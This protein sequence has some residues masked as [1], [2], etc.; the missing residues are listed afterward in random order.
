MGQHPLLVGNILG[1]NLHLVF[2]GTFVVFRS[3]TALHLIDGITASCLT[4]NIHCTITALEGKRGL[5][6]VLRTIA[7]TLL[8]LVEHRF[9]VECAISLER[10]NLN[11]V[12]KEVH[13][14]VAHLVASLEAGSHLWIF[15]GQFRMVHA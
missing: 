3:R 4:E 14:K 13:G 2:L 15:Y 1:I 11:I 9:Q 8:R 12:A 10:G 7:E 5:T 6:D